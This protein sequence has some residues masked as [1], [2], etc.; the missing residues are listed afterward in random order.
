MSMPL[1]QTIRLGAYL[2]K[3]KVLRR[4]R[5]PILV[6]LEPLFAC[7]L[8]CAGCGKIEQPAMLLKQRMPVEQAVGAI[9]ESGAPM[10]SIAGGEPLMH[11][12]VDEIVR[13]LLDR[14]KIVFLCT[15]A[16]LLPKHLPRLRP[17][18]KFA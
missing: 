15:N 1:R 8:K 14:G 18:R 17:H 3:Q 12:Q 16:V 7:N 9:V 10:V 11:K 6:E 13:Q 4:K 5:F 2:A